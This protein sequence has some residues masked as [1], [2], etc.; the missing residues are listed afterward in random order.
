MFFF[1]SKVARMYKFLALKLKPTSGQSL[2]F[3]LIFFAVPKVMIFVYVITMV[4]LFMTFPTEILVK[5]TCI[6]GRADF[7]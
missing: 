2:K 3:Y 4:V 7:W 5:L 1:Y 6:K